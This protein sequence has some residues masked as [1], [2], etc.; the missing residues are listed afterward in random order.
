MSGCSASCFG[1]FY[2]LNFV[3]GA[4]SAGR[5]RSLVSAIV[6]LSKLSRGQLLQVPNPTSSLWSSMLVALIVVKQGG[7]GPAHRPAKQKQ[8]PTLERAACEGWAWRHKRCW[9]SQRTF[10][11]PCQPRTSPGRTWPASLR[12][13]RHRE[14]LPTTELATSPD[15]QYTAMPESRS[16]GRAVAQSLLTLNT[17]RHWADPSTSLSPGSFC[18][19]QWLH[20]VDPRKSRTKR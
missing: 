19:S 8:G 5:I 2:L 11:R 13:L 17:N 9:L 3:P 10:H 20:C 15:A 6:C 1:I 14:A 7:A 16:T 12:P 4:I 18:R